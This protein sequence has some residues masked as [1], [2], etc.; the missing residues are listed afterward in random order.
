MQTPTPRRAGIAR[1][2]L[3]HLLQQA[4]N[5]DAFE[6]QRSQRRQ[7][8][9]RRR[10]RLLSGDICGMFGQVARPRTRGVDHD[11]SRPNFAGERAPAPANSPQ[12]RR[13]Q[14]LDL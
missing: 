5:A 9:R 6:N 2:A 13:V 7:Q 14:S 11:V 12:L 1:R 4:G 10:R 3:E 8:R